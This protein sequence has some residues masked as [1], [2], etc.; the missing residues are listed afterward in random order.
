L[1][2]K[3]TFRVFFEQL[4]TLGFVENK[5]LLKE[6]HL[7]MLL[8]AAKCSEDSRGGQVTHCDKSFIFQH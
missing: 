6:D 3:L 8:Q 1:I 4:P 5:G 2:S 7:P